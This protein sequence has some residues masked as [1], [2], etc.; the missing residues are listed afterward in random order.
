[1]PLTGDEK[2]TIE[3]LERTGY[4]HY[5]Y[6]SAPTTATG[7]TIF[8]I[9]PDWSDDHDSDAGCDQKVFDKDLPAFFATMAE[10]TKDMPALPDRYVACVTGGIWWIA[11]RDKRGRIATGATKSLAIRNALRKLN[12]GKD[13]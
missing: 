4:V 8:I 13:V 12:P 11:T 1:M 5:L 9:R 6:R 10:E 7:F 2:V 3:R